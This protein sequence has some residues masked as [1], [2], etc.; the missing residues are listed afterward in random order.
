MPVAMSSLGLAIKPTAPSS[1]ARNVT[2]D[3]LSVS[4]ET[5]T[6]GIGRSRISFSRKSSPS[7]LGISTSRVSTSGF[8]SRIIARAPSGSGAAPMASMSCWA[9]MISVR[10]FRI[11]AESSTI[12]TLIFFMVSSKQLHGA[13]DFG[14][15]QARA[16]VVFAGNNS[17]VVNIAQLLH[18]H[19]AAGREVINLARIDVDQVACGDSDFLGLQKLQYELGVA[20]PDVR[21][22]QP[23]QHVAAAEHFGL[24]VRAPLAQLGDVVDQYLHRI[25]A[26]A[27]RGAERTRF[28]RVAVRQHEMIHAA[29]TI[30]AVP[31]AGGDTGTQHRYQQ[32]V[33]SRHVIFTG[34]QLG[35]IGTEV[36]IEIQIRRQRL[37]VSVTHPAPFPPVH[38]PSGRAA[39]PGPKGAPWLTITTRRWRRI[40]ISI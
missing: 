12:R 10:T 13:F 8:N 30:A 19:L 1:S 16:V 27:R 39:G 26:V 18:H 21:H 14:F 9:L 5:I 4:V 3:P 24:E 32:H 36:A 25:S 17:F 22:G 28:A 38:T 37:M 23:A 7:I 34:E 11:S 15:P 6:T 29:D 2:S 31:Y 35:R 20:L 40:C 33:A